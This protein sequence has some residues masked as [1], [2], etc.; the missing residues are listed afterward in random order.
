MYK[1]VIFDFDGTICDTGEGIKKSAKYALDAFN[2]PSN[3]WQTLDCFIGPPLLVTFQEQFNQS[4]ADA[5]LLVQKFRERY[6]NTGIYECE[7]YNGIKQLLINLKVDGIKIGIASSKPQVFVETLLNKFAIAK[8]FDSVCATSFAAD[9]E[10][11]QNIIARCLKE[12]ETEPKDALMVGDRFYDIDGAKADMV[13]G[14][15][16]LWGYG[17]KFEFIECGAKYIVDKVED[18]E[19]IA[20]GLYERTEKVNGIYNGRVLTMHVDDVLLCNDQKANRECVDHPGGVAV[21]GITDDDMV[22]LV[23]Q[24]R[25]PYKETIY[26]IPAGKLEKG[27]DPFEAGKREFKEETGGVAEEY[28]SLGEIYPSPGYTNE[29]IRL[30]AAKNITFEEQNLDDDEFLQVCQISFDELIRRIMSGEIKDAK[31]IAA[32]FKLKELMNK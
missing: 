30:Y 1:S 15:G 9:C 16:A 27:E 4:A 12:L 11:K 6:T 28:I 8:Y 17:S 13:D 22:V 23:R 19:S 31:T 7:L 18:I 26:E 21:I 25:Y 32:A 14:A 10:S 3:D 20:L 29:I 24:F 2:I 5:D